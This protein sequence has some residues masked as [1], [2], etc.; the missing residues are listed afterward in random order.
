[1]NRTI[2][3]IKNKSNNKLY[4]GSSI[5]YKERKKQHLYTLRRN[6]SSSILL[7]R[8]WNKYG[9]SNF[10]F[11]ILEENV[12]LDINLVLREE[13]FIVKYNTIEN[14]YNIKLP[15]TEQGFYNQSYKISKLL[16]D[17]R[18]LNPPPNLKKITPEQWIKERAINPDYK[19]PKH[20]IKLKH[21]YKKREGCKVIISVNKEGV[22]INRWDSIYKCYNDIGAKPAG[23]RVCCNSN[24]NYTKLHNCKGLFLFFENEYNKERFISLVNYIKPERVYKKNPENIIPYAE[25][26]LFRKEISIIHPIE[27][28]K[29]FCSIKECAD[30]LKCSAS[31]VQTLIKGRQNKGNGRM[32]NITNIKEWKIN[33]VI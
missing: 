1:M 30:F 17:F 4:I 12:P 3:S 26:N 31:R 24:T 23:V 10:I 15:Y 6:A 18:T 11:E 32:V 2:Y 7:Q 29:T 21:L 13:E 33:L 14:G 22:I 8:A 28:I 19:V 5:N 9:E 20:I 27:G 16:K 25:R